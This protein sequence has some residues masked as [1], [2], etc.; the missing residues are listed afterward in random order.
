MLVEKHDDGEGAGIVAVWRFG[1]RPEHDDAIAGKYSEPALCCSGLF[2]LAKLQLPSEDASFVSGGF[3][4]RDHAFGAGTPGK[5]WS[6]R[7]RRRS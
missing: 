2:L 6:M 7:E 5:S 1:Q 3:S 4:F